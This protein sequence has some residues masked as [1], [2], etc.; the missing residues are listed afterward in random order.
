MNG[1]QT[2]ETLKATGGEDR[3]LRRL[4]RAARQARSNAAQHLELST[5]HTRRVCHRADV[6]DPVAVL[7]LG[8]LRVIDGA[9]TIGML[10]AFQMLLGR[11]PRPGQRAGGA[12]LAAAGSG[13]RPPPAGRRA[14][15]PGRPAGSIG[16]SIAAHRVRLEGALELRNVTF[17]YSQ[18]DPPLLRDFSLTLGPGQR[19]AL[20]GG[21]GS[22]KSTVARLV[23]GLYTP[24]SGEIL[25]DGRPSPRSAA[26]CS[27]IR[28]RSSTRTSSCSRG[29]SATT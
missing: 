6:A 20:V 4:G 23:C 16:G 1:L 24:W 7:C 12:R 27:P 18:L 10:V 14:P 22:G 3:L 21:S 11:V 19:V 8:G 15:L 13:R 26:T 2:I 28:W 17:G 25:F 29:R 5:C 9:L